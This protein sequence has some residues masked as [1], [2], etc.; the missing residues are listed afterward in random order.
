MAYYTLRFERYVQ[1]SQTVEVEA[2]SLD[3]AIEHARKIEIVYEGEEGDAKLVLNEGCWEEEWEDTVTYPRLCSVSDSA[4]NELARVNIPTPTRDWLDE[5]LTRQWGRD[6]THSPSYK[7][8]EGAFSTTSYLW[9]RLT[10]DLTDKGCAELERERL[11]RSTAPAL[12][13]KAPSDI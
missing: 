10:P 5:C 11:E 9:D 6:E 12:G 3:A 7:E 13:M 1:F 8:I 4:G 2:E